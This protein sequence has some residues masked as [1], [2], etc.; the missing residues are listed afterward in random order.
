MRSIQED[1]GA[2]A[3]LDVKQ[4]CLMKL[5]TLTG[6]PSHEQRGHRAPQC[7]SDH[8]EANAAVFKAEK[9]EL[10]SWEPGDHNNGDAVAGLT[11]HKFVSAPRKPSWLSLVDVT[12]HSSSRGDEEN[13]VAPTAAP[14]ED[15]RIPIAPG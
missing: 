13:V 2:A 14:R 9:S 7:F 12:E 10:C 4:D 15:S 11:I 5:L 1:L 3:G 6:D 8:D